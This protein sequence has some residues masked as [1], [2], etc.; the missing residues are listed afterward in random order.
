MFAPS[1]PSSGVLTQER[2][3]TGPSQLAFCRH[4][5]RGDV[6]AL[7]PEQRFPDPGNHQTRSVEAGLQQV[8]MPGVQLPRLVSTSRLASTSF[9]DGRLSG[10]I[11]APLATFF[12]P[13]ASNWD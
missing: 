8:R 7:A 3:K 12:R 13:E 10:G 5:A 6:R 1:R 11:L 9:R 4:G 2:I